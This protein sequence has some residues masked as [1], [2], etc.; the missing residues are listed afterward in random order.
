MVKQ[1]GANLG[2]ERRHINLLGKK[3][4]ISIGESSQFGLQESASLLHRGVKHLEELHER[5]AHI[6]GGI[7]CHIVVENVAPAK[8]AGIFGIEAEHQSHAQHIEATE[9]FGVIVAI[10][11]NKRIVELPYNVAG[12][13]RHFKF[14][15]QMLVAGFHKEAQ[16]VVF[17]PE[18]A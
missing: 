13:H 15:L 5:I 12:F 6:L 7:V 11:G 14:L 18:V 3:S 10:L 17:A 16:A 4:A 2:G 8:Y 1:Q 9:R